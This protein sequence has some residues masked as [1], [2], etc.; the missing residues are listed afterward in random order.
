MGGSR[1]YRDVTRPT[2][3]DRRFHRQL[4][5]LIVIG[6]PVVAVAFVVLAVLSATSGNNPAGFVFFAVV[7]AF[8]TVLGVMR[9][10]ARGD[11][12]SQR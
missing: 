7:F 2:D 8:G 12:G 9:L 3:S 6:A 1:E 10:R 4:A 11:R 5:L